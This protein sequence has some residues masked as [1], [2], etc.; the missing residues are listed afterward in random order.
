M[1]FQ[2]QQVVSAPKSAHGIWQSAS[3]VPRELLAGFC[4][5][6]GGSVGMLTENMKCV[7][8]EQ[9]LG[10][11]ATVCPDGTPNL[12]PK[13]TTIV[14]DDDHLVFAHICSPTTI[15][16]LRHNPAIE[17]NVVDAFRRKGYRFKG[18]PT[19]LTRGPV[20]EQIMSMYR[21]ENG[22]GRLRD[23]DRRVHGVVLVRGE[24][25][26]PLISPAYDDRLTSAPRRR[27]ERTRTA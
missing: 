23:A 11:V 20:F 22:Q 24:R 19:V 26:A 16:N 4:D 12:S 8:R 10:F 27:D 13:G 25:A 6:E 21:G 18:A 3:V 1:P 5:D 14:W 17:I 9:R 7:V 2:L 15:E